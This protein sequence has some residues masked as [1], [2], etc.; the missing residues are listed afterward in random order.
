MA[1]AV[2]SVGS[3]IQPEEHVP[4]ALRL[5][6]RE[7]LLVALSPV[8]RTPP[9]GD[10]AAQPFLNGGVLVETAL[11]MD[12]LKGLLRAVE[13][14][15]GRVRTGEKNAPRTIDLDILVYED[16]GGALRHL[17]DDVARYRFDWEAVRALAPHLALPPAPAPMAMEPVHLPA[18]DALGLA[19][20]QR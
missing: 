18:L 17:D 2:V 16:D 14:R 5:L 9:Q 8:V 3:N 4:Q 20:A 13:A 19:R 10:P 1:R 7:V 6:G 11:D 15:L 12:A